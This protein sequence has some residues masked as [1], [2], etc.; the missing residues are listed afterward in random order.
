MMNTVRS[1][2]STVIRTVHGFFDAAFSAF[3]LCVAFLGFAR[4]GIVLGTL[5][6]LLIIGI[7]FLLAAAANRT[8]AERFSN[9]QSLELP[10]MMQS[11]L[12]VVDTFELTYGFDLPI[13]EGDTGA[14][15]A[16]TGADGVDASA[17]EGNDTGASPTA[18]RASAPA[19]EGYG[20]SAL[21]ISTKSTG[22]IFALRF[23]LT[24]TRLDDVKRPGPVDGKAAETPGD[25]GT[26]KKPYRGFIDRFANPARCSA[27]SIR[28]PSR[29]RTR[30]KFDNS[31][32][33][34]ALALPV[35]QNIYRLCTYEVDLYFTTA[36]IYEPQIFLTR[37]SLLELM[38][39]EFEAAVEDAGN[40]GTTD[41]AEDKTETARDT[42]KP[43]KAD[44]PKLS[45]SDMSPE[46]RQVV[47]DG[48][49]RDMLRLEGIL[50]SNSASSIDCG[51]G[52][53]ILRRICDAQDAMF[54]NGRIQF[55]TLV[56]FF[57]GLVQLALLVIL[58]VAVPLWLWVSRMLA[59]I[60]GT[61]TASATSNIIDT[62]RLDE[63]YPA[64]SGPLSA[65]VDILPMIGF[66]GTIVGIAGA[67][68]QVAGVKSSDA[69]VEALSLGAMTTS[70][71]VAFETTK[72]ALILSAI[73][74][75]LKLMM[76]RAQSLWFREGV[77]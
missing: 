50:G 71:G 40:A 53:S 56:V 34:V 54:T 47:T 9:V 43:E 48:F 14:S 75:F 65:S 77:R 46:H 39:Q 51:A 61:R 22:E 2:G 74:L 24:E 17:E 3:F 76:D 37:D 68:T 28:L 67:M 20:T 1:V 15:P 32:G 21:S 35:T 69:I 73:L 45:L 10:L 11:D 36:Q 62:R 60:P 66:F 5:K 25:A 16:A 12:R 52:E 70:I 26:Q 33:D 63:V 7:S 18:N 64:L 58:A 8:L 23:A 57:F 44:A 29:E 30:S 59:R 4:P 6:L 27:L 41:D 55:V 38:K 49:L 13:E 31:N 42:A 19:A 72:F